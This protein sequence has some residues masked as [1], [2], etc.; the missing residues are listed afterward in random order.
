MQGLGK[1]GVHQLKMLE[2]GLANVWSSKRSPMP[3]G[4]VF[5]QMMRHAYTIME[6]GS[7][8]ASSYDNKGIGL[9]EI[10]KI[11]TPAS[12]NPKQIIPKDLIH[13][14]I[15]NP[16]ISWYGNSTFPGTVED[17]FVEYTYPAKDCSEVHMIWTDTP[18][19]IT[20][21]NDSNSYIKALRSPK[22]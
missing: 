8:R 11:T 20:C 15:L 7:R 19:W 12:I 14:A 5:P 22:I 2:W 10:E 18:C 1:S 6:V 16:P 17:Q 4:K 3:I 9:T 13:E 21:W